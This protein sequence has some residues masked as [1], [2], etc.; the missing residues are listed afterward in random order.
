MQNSKS[1]DPDVGA[2]IA[3]H[4]RHSK[5]PWQTPKSVEDDPNTT[6]KMDAILN[7]PTYR[8][9]D[10]DPDFLVRDDTRGLRLHLDY[11]KAE[12]GL[13]DN[14]I[15]Q[16]IVV[17]GSTRIPERATALRQVEVARTRLAAK[18]E[19]LELQRELSIAER[20]LAKSKYYD[21]ARDFG[22][23]VGEAEV[24]PAGRLVAMTGG[25]PGIMEAVNRG[26]DDVGA[27]SVGLNITLPHEQYPNPYI[28]PDLCFRFHYFGLRKMHF[29]RR[30][31]ALVVFPGGYGTMDELFET[32]TLLQTE[33]IE[34]LPVILV[35]Q[36]YWRRAF[37][38]DFLVDEGVIAPE[39][40]D[41]FCF[42]ESADEI[43]GAI[44]LWH[45]AAGRP[46]TCED[47]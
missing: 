31:R 21:I 13:A 24:G 40:R 14:R 7:S 16:T 32:L 34:P 29:L 47:A 33:K 5:L 8:Q 12:Y 18:P 20:I 25:C 41:L 37:D 44:R 38:P 46:I 19:D 36:D 6:S 3:S 27:R 9:A 42:A 22:R 30:A 45:Q 26:A 17:F 1:P 2:Q 28:T 15:T 11:L 23:L 4:K 43:W 39:D 35:G 10:Q